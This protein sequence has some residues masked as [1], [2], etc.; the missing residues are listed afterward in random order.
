MPDYKGIDYLRRWLAYKRIRVDMRYRYY[1]MKY[2]LDIQGS[3]IPTQFQS[4]QTVLGWCALSVDL[5][6]GRL[7][8]DGFRNDNFMLDEIYNVNNRDVLFRSSVLSAL[9][10]SCSFIYISRGAD[11]YPR[12]QSIDG[13]N[14]TGVIDPTTNLLTEGYAVISRDEWGRPVTEAYFIAGETQFYTNGQ[15]TDIYSS[16]VPYA[17]LVPVIYRPD[18]RRP[19]GHSRISRTNMSLMRYAARVLWRSE[20]SAEFYSFPQKY[21]LGMDP[22]AEFN[23][24]MATITSFLRIDKDDDGDHPVIGQFQQQSMLPYTEQLKMVAS[25]FAGM[26]GLT[27]DDLGFSTANPATREAIEAGH[28]NLRVMAEDAKGSFGTGFLNAGYLAACLRDDYAYQRQ[29]I[30]ATKPVWLPVF[31]VGSSELAGI[32]DAIGKIQQSFPDYFTEDKLHEL[33]GL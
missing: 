15:L 16:S 14:A 25:T 27:L 28:E 23:N 29:Q 12:M 7:R 22:D 1:E 24:R 31:T 18:A 26:N 5:L 13:G 6:A 2:A 21:V 30:Y 20:V 32:G 4:L 19:F 10:S 17:L 8:F 9:I 33:T 11:G 3:I